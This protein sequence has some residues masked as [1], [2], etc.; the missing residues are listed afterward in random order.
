MRKSMGHPQYVYRPWSEEMKQR[1]SDAAVTRHYG[2][3][4]KA[5][6]ARAQ[7]MKELEKR[8]R[9]LMA[10]RDKLTQE[11]TLVRANLTHLRKVRAR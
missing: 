7:K 6:E 2:S 5:T 11:L 3:L 8:E 10:D 1:S 9:E 4:E